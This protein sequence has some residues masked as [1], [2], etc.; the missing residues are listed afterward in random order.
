MELGP[1]SPSPSPSPT[2]SQSQPQGSDQFKDAAMEIHAPPSDFASNV[3]DWGDLL[4][5]TVDD[6]LVVHL[7]S[8]GAQPPPPPEVTPEPPE[9]VFPEPS[10][11][12]PGKVRKRDP[13]MSCSNFLAGFVPCACPEVD[14]KLMELEEEEAGHAKKRART[15]RAPPGVARC[16]V[17]ACGA[18]IK[19]LKGYHR[20][21]RVC[22]RCANSTTV[23]IDGETKRYCQQCGKFHVLSDFDEGKRSCR[24]KLERHNNRR[25][26]KPVD[27]KGAKE[28]DFQGDI[29]IED[30]TGD[31]DA[32]K[33]FPQTVQKESFVESEGGQVSSQGTATVTRDNSDGF[34]SL[35]D[36]GETQMDGGKHNSKQALS[37]SHYD[38]KS[39]YSSMCPTGRISFKLYDWNPAEF[40]RRLRHQIFQW[41]SSMPVELEGYIRPGC[42]ILT[43]F[44][45]M[46]RFMWMKVSEDPV[47]Y[48]H[49]FIVAPGGMLS[50]R[51]NILV[52]LNNMILHVAKN[53]TSVIQ[54]KVN[55]RAPRLHYVHP[56][57]FEAGKPMEFVACGSNLLQ[58]K[59]RF[60]L[61]FS[62]KY[63]E[64]DYRP[65]SS[66]FQNEEASACNFDHQ[67]CKIH[68]PHTE[69]N[70]FGPVFIEV[71]N[72]AGLSNFIPVL[73][74]DKE[75][76]SEMCIIQQRLDGSFSAV[77]SLSNSCEVSS[78]RQIAFSEVILDIA[79]LLKKPGVENVKQIITATQIQRFNCLLN[80]LLSVESTFI[81][82][83]VLRN[84]TTLMDNVDLKNACNGSSDA[85][86]RLLQKHMDYALELLCQQQ[87][88]TG[89]LSLHSRNLT[90]KSDIVSQTDEHSV[91][92][93]PSQ[94]MEINV[95]GKLLVMA[96]ST[97]NRS[98]TIPLPNRQVV[99]KANLIKEWP[100]KASP[101]SSSTEVLSSRPALTFFRFR[102]AI[103]VLTTAAVC[104]G[105]CAAL[106]HPHKVSEFAVSIRRCL[107][108]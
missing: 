32:G 27:S 63:L 15:A 72:E 17:P 66:K 102:P 105:V 96:D 28:K 4:D 35:A 48:V 106:F 56:T 41:L 2:S 104:L 73:M 99:S 12:D 30:L 97:S 19:E 68:V 39:A 10:D 37:S 95:N 107:L 3:W 86:L 60:L 88:T 108:N 98:E 46:P 14:E 94:D 44:V 82:E 81:L 92:P 25:R 36:S 22:L 69:A 1:T 64:C 51:G 78:L 62:G 6:D 43:V 85:D 100:S 74:G 54:A 38:N 61:S 90:A 101:C 77:D 8:G 84:L 93:L 59:L 18:D 24:R 80:F 31:G 29:P 76:C 70:F 16:Q 57:C 7:D 67:L 34:A 71:E 79:W 11:S 13:R 40:P 45:A 50:G 49:K 91:V 103:F 53:G 65:A 55:V 20:R 87:H 26:R 42:I 47:S 33:D 89:N 52:Y 5:F 75:T 21:H 58:P 23:V 9:E 83:K